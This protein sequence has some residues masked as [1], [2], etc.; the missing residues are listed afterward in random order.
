MPTGNDVTTLFAV[1]LPEPMLLAGEERELVLTSIKP[2]PEPSCCSHILPMP[3]FVTA[4][5]VQAVKTLVS[6]LHILDSKGNETRGMYD[7]TNNS[8]KIR[9]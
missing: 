8:D 9:T 4:C 2:P 3:K 5:S 6:M 7:Y 1:S